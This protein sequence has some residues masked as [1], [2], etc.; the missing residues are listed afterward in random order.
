MCVAGGWLGRLLRLK[1]RRKK[2][3]AREAGGFLTQPPSEKLSLAVDGDKYR[4]P[5]PD[6]MQRL[7]GLGTLSPKCDVTI[8]SLPSE[9]SEPCRGGGR[10]VWRIKRK[11]KRSN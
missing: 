2:M 3:L 10:K 6:F 5:Q 11:Y 9:F 7:R 1:T 4:D 8:R